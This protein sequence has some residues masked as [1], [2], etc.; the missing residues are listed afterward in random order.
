MSAERLA[1]ALHILKPDAEWTIRGEEYTGL[2]WLDESQT[3]PTESEIA[4]ID[5]QVDAEI[6]ER[7]VIAARQLAYP[8]ALTF[9]EAYT[10]KEIGGDSTKWDAYVIAYNKVRADNPKPK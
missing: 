3:K 9:M 7:A 10:E 6:A 2:K 4:A 8:D 1:I 5:S